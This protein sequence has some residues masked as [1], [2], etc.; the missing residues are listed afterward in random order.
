MLSLYGLYL[1]TRVAK[2]NLVSISWIVDIPA[3]FSPGLNG[4]SLP[5]T[6]EIRLY[7]FF[8]PYPGGYQIIN[9]GIFRMAT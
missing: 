6:E 3:P 7:L 4:L 9:S 1:E 8:P 5:T 2:I